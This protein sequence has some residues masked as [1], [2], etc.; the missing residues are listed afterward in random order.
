[1]DRIYC[2][3]DC[4]DVPEEIIDAA[5]RIFDNDGADIPDEDAA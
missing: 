5:K 2:A 3:A 4:E 1:V